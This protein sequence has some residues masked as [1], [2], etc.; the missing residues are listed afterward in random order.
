MILRV[1]FRYRLLHLFYP[2]IFRTGKLIEYDIIV[3][4]IQTTTFHLVFSTIYYME[5]A[6]YGVFISEYLCRGTN[7]RGTSD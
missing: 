2:G 7:E 6:T 5:S 1:F 4:I 3:Y